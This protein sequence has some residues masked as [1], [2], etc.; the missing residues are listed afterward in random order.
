VAVLERLGH[1]QVE[2]LEA[3]RLGQVVVGAEAEAAD[4]V[5]AAPSAVEEDHRHQAQLGARRAALHQ[6]PSRRALGIITSGDDQ[7]R[8][9]GPCLPWASPSSPSLATAVA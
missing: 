7:V 5:L 4:A 1:A 8:R 2:L 9:R 6:L 3:E